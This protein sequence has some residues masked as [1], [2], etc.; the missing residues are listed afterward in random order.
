M[1][2]CVTVPVAT[3]WTS[4]EAPREL[5]SSALAEPPD[6]H[7]WTAALGGEQRRGLH[8]RTL[9]QALL[10]EPVKVLEAAGDWV[11]VRLP[12]QPH[13]PDGAGYT[14]WVRRSHVG[15]DGSAP[16]ADVLAVSVLSAPC[17]P[18][19]G[20]PVVLSYGTVLGSLGLDGDTAVVALPDGRPARIRTG[21]V[22]GA[23]ERVGVDELL[24]SARQFVGLRY[25]WGG[26]SGWGVDCSGLVHLVHRVHGVTV[27]RDASDQHEQA[28]PW[29]SPQE[30]TDGGLFFFA[31]AGARAY[32]VGLVTGNEPLAMLHAPESG[33]GDGGLVE[34]APVAPDRIA[35]LVGAGTF[36]PLP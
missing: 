16:T 14:G 32:H 11:Q 30:A 18:E 5:D 24:A 36:L 6:M 2:T 20:D 21:A 10:G 19:H 15:E 27:P 13:G 7:A 4:P 9:T 35:T 33:P 26:T 12:W 8:G 34:D 25:L 1:S 3:V 29:S 22:R 28:Q 17:V 31:R 23:T